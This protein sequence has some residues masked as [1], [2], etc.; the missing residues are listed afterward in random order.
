MCSKCDH[1]LK[2]FFKVGYWYKWNGEKKSEVGYIGD[3]ICMLD[4]KWRKCICIDTGTFAKFEG[5]EVG[6]NWFQQTN[7]DPAD[8]YLKSK[9]DPNNCSSTPHGSK[10]HDDLEEYDKIDKIVKEPFFK[11]GWWYKSKTGESS[12]L[13]VHINT[14]MELFFDGSWHK[15]VA[16]DEGLKKESHKKL[17]RAAFEETSDGSYEDCKWNWASDDKMLPDFFERRQYI[18]IAIANTPIAVCADKDE[19][20]VQQMECFIARVSDGSVTELFIKRKRKLV[21]VKVED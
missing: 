4:C 1:N 2:E 18:S 15:C 21:N 9:T 17:E 5:M 14:D 20:G 11:V 16:T 7:E 10:N 3:M 8:F 13:G 6:W 19:K 12:K